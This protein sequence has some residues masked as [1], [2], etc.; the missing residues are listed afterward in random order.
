MSSRTVQII[1]G[2]ARQH[3][4]VDGATNALLVKVV[5]PSGG[6]GGGGTEYA[7]DAAHTTGDFGTLSLVV[8][9]DVAGS[10][11][12]ADGDYAPLQVDASGSLRVTITGGSASGTQYNEDAAHSSGDTGTLALVVRND[13]PGTLAGTDGDYAALQVDATGR[14]RVAVD[15]SVAV[16]VTDNGGSLTVDGSV[17]V[18]NFPA[19]QAV[20]D[21]GGS[22]TVDGSVSVSG[23]VTADQGTSPWVVGDGG[24]S[25][26]VDGTVAA[27]QSGAWTVGVNN[28]PTV[29]P[30]NDNGGSL[31]VD[32]T[33]AVTQ[34]THASLNATV[35]LQDST[36]GTLV[37]V[38]EDGQS[39]FDTEKNGIPT[40]F[41]V[42][43]SPTSTDEFWAVGR[44]STDGGIWVAVQNPLLGTAGN[45]GSLG[46][47]ESD[48]HSI[49]DPGV[50]MLAVRNDSATVTGADGDYVPLMTNSSGALQVHVFNGSLSSVTAV[51]SVGTVSN[52]NQVNAVFPGATATA[53]GKAEDEVHASGDVGVMALAVRQDSPTTLTSADGDY[54][55]LSVDAKNRLWT[56]AELYTASAP[57]D[58][59]NPL[60]VAFTNVNMGLPGSSAASLG[61][62]EDAAHASGDTGVMMLAVRNDT[63]SALATTNGDYI[64]LTTDSAGRLHVVPGGG[65]ITTVTTVSSV[66][67]VIAGTGATNL[68]K[69]EDAA[70]TSGATGV[71]ALAVRSDT[72]TAL[73]TTN[74]DYIPLITDSTGKLHTNVGVIVPGTA[75]TNL[76]KEEDAAHASGDTGVMMLAVRNDTLSALAG[77]TGDYIP[78]TTDSQGR[79]YI[80][81]AGVTTIA[82]SGSTRGRPIQITATSSTGTT[83][84]TATTTA[85]QIDR[86]F[87][88][89][90]NTSSAA[91]TVTIEFGTTGAGS[92]MDVIV[93]AN[94]TILA[95]DGAVIGGAATDTVSAYATTG[96]VINA[97]GRVE[98]LT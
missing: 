82:L 8:R 19:T 36:L 42:T 15:A 50:M 9:K 80:K 91:V 78:L 66:S 62:L 1:G 75:A 6:G 27:T 68:G 2:D 16:A 92:E 65:T 33:V 37:S 14:L 56:N 10:L 94:E 35:R 55:S 73:A 59:L 67:A 52:I 63:A 97:F 89:L 47:R 18:S 23:T 90:T 93:P 46:R 43:D 81:E 48:A 40:M 38:V 4:F 34:A 45:S 21:G 77:T 5:N 29:Y 98:R 22:L 25:L 74:G 12:S 7:E 11:V 58:S 70:H 76:G 57:I 31:T 69:A 17:S 79:L 49:L 13:T 54:A 88:Y 32:G 30:V 20:S 28:F 60:F 64:P 51:T 87:I 71:M 72:A 83:L 26:T 3:A 61:K 24:G 44:M 41:V 95:V 96:S 85:G 86:V 39:I 84:H 53:L